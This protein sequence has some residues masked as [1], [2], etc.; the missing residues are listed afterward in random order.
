[1]E[2]VLFDV[3]D[4]LLDEGKGWL[5]DDPLLPGVRRTLA[6]IGLQYRL[7]ILSNTRRATRADLALE[8]TRLG[9]VRHFLAILTSSDIGWRKPHPLAFEAA[10]SVLRTPATRTV[11]VGNDLEG[12]V[13]GAKAMG[14]RTVHFRWSPRYRLEP[15]S[16]AER[17]TVTIEEFD[18]LTIALEEARGAPTPPRTAFVEEASMFQEGLEEK[19]EE[20]HAL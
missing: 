17:A 11:M 5:A 6:E 10:L 4:T 15:V 8:L 7:A 9:I 13:A 1:M 19:E 20:K 3:G 12:D 2:A 18:D 14:M 16:D